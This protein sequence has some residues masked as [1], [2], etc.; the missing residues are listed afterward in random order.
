MKMKLAKLILF[1]IFMVS[2]LLIC[3]VVLM[4]FLLVGSFIFSNGDYLAL[5]HSY[6]VPEISYIAI[7]TIISMYIAAVISIKVVFF[8]IKKSNYMLDLGVRSLIGD[9]L[10]RL[11]SNPKLKLFSVINRL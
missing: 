5:L 1:L 8:V 3:S 11:Y 6:D 10:Y 9:E 2:T 7:T 4:L